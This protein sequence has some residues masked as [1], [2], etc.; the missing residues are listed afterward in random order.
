MRMQAMAWAFDMG[1]SIVPKMTT[2][3]GIECGEY[4]KRFC[5]ERRLMKVMAVDRLAVDGDGSCIVYMDL[6]K[7]EVTPW[8]G[9]VP[10]RSSGAAWWWLAWTATN[11]SL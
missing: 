11:K 6:I 4:W 7:A 8:T 10:W 9:K 1:A 2:D 3:G 5:V